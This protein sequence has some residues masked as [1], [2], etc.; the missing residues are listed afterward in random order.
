[1]AITG[2]RGPHDM[3]VDARILKHLLHEATDLLEE[4][5]THALVEKHNAMT[6]H[7]LAQANWRMTAT[8]SWAISELLPSP[9]E[10]GQ[11]A[12]L[13]AP[14]PIFS[15]DD[16]DI[17]SQ[18]AGFVVRVNRLHERARRLDEL[19]RG[20]MVS[21]EPQQPDWPMPTPV[22]EQQSASVIP[23]FGQGN[24]DSKDADPVGDSLTQLR[25]AMA[26]RD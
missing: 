16:G 4:A 1:M 15:R 8:C 19:S 24:Q 6:A 10:G 25:W 9:G 3:R 26:A 17:S 13:H 2:N 5:Q 23:L 22:G 20:P 12:R 14:A 7:V 11:A 21:T 18:L